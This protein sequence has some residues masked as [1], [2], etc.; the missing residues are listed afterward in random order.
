MGNKKNYMFFIEKLLKILRIIGGQEWRNVSVTQW[1][2]W[3]SSYKT[4]INKLLSMYVSV[5]QI[6]FLCKVFITACKLSPD[7]LVKQ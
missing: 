4:N 7:L 5:L 1:G 3:G 6:S 2:N